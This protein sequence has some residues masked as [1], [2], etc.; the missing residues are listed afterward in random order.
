MRHSLVT[1]TMLLSLISA[2][3]CLANSGEADGGL[4]LS[5]NLAYSR[6]E[7]SLY[8]DYFAAY[9]YNI[10]YENGYGGSAA[11]GYNFGDKFRFE[12]EGSLNINEVDESTPLGGSRYDGQD[13][14]VMVTAG[15]AN[16]YMDFRNNTPWTSYIMI[17]GGLA[18]V[19]LDQYDDG[20]EDNFVPA[21]Q[22]G[23]GVGYRISDLI[24]LDLQYRY[25]LTDEFDNDLGSYEYHAHRLMAGARMTF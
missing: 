13:S 12:V 10:R 22:F 20:V 11:V 16:A 24:T 2:T 21:G 8:T 14:I 3:P 17:G 4:Y 15:M 19:D 18:Y 5:A 23:L 25:F 9:R 6:L 7:D 1:G